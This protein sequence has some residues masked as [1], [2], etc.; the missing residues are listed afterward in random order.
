MSTSIFTFDHNQKKFHDAIGVKEEYLDELA[1]KLSEVV[2]SLKLN[3]QTQE[4]IDCS[5]SEIVQAIAEELS[6][7]QLVLASSFYIKEKI[8]ELENQAHKK[9]MMSKND[10][11]EDIKKGLADAVIKGEVKSMSDLPHEL[12]IQL[13]KFLEDKLKEEDED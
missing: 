10:I 5:P 9:Y 11:P 12:Q 8:Q 1:E 2:K 7:S 3:M 4:V 6:Y 13:I